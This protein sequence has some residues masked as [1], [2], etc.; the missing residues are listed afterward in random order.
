MLS[1]YGYIVIVFIIFILMIQALYISKFSPNKIKV[2]AIIVIMIMLLRDIS[3]MVLSLAHNIKH[4]YLLKS[5]FFLN[6]ISIPLLALIV[7]YIFIRKDNINFSY[8]FIIAIVLAGLY[9]IMIYKC[10]AIV[11]INEI[12]GYT[13]IFAK[14]L[15][16]YWICVTVNTVILF[17]TIALSKNKNINK[18]GIS[19]IICAS[20]ITIIELILWIIGIRILPENVVGDMLWSIIIVYA[21]SKIRKKGR[22][23]V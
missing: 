4:L 14:D 23:V 3:L 2:A 20:F 9:G 11:Q 19:M 22:S 16:L 21:L 1:F 13:I 10:P 18:L 12:Y 8:I 6:F 17:V 15:Y 5:I 7:I